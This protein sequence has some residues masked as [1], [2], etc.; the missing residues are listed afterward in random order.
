MLGLRQNLLRGFFPLFWLYIA[1]HGFVSSADNVRS[2]PNES[3]F[4]LTFPAMGTTVELAGFTNDRTTAEAAFGAAR[5][6]VERLLQVLSDYEDDSELSRLSAQAGSGRSI[7]V[8]TDLWKVIQAADRWNRITGG[9]FDSSIGSLTRLWRKSRR[10]R[11]VPAPE[12]IVAALKNSGWNHIV[13]DSQ[14]RSIEL[15]KKGMFLDLGAIAKGYIVDCAFEILQKHGIK[16]CMVNAGGDLRCG[17]APPDRDGWRVAIAPL[18]E[19]GPPLRVLTMSNAAIATSGDLWQF[20]MI[21]GVRRSHILDP[22]TG[23]GV[24]GPMSVSAIASTAMD[25][26]AAATAL[27]VLGHQKGCQLAEE[28]PDIEVLVVSQVEERAPIRYTV[29]PGFTR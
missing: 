20:S 25:A 22:A 3:G 26:D 7:P 14:T 5:T 12:Q 2:N 11:E 16:Q 18:S 17:D 28:Q 29:T 1:L 19:N 15:K 6:E 4:A 21:D 23:L 13:L 9:A 10:L 24:E 27:S 8:S